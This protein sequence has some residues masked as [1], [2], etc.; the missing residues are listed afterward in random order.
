MYSDV[1]LLSLHA[2]LQIKLNS[3]TNKVYHTIGYRYT[4]WLQAHYRPSSVGAL[5]EANSLGELEPTL[6]LGFA[7]SANKI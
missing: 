1:H 2:L 6:L 4:A 3:L 7:S 5:S